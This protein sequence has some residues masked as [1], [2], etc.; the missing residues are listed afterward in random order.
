VK[1][2]LCS[3]LVA[4]LP[5]G[6]VLAGIVLQVAAAIR[7]RIKTHLFERGA[8][9][10]LTMPI[11]TAIGASLPSAICWPAMPPRPCGWRPG[12]GKRCLT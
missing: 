2:I 10:V 9:G 4:T 7:I 8:G 1:R 5:F 12:R 11:S 6:S 3:L